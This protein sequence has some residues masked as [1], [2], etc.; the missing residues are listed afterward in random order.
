MRNLTLAAI[1]AVFL[2][3]QSGC[4]GSSDQETPCAGGVVNTAAA[5]STDIV[6][7]AR[8]DQYVHGPW[9][10]SVRPGDIK[11]NARIRIYDAP[12]ANLAVTIDHRYKTKNSKQ[13][14]VLNVVHPS[15]EV[16]DPIRIKALDPVQ[17]Q[18]RATLNTGS[19]ELPADELV[20]MQSRTLMATRDFTVIPTRTRASFIVRPQLDSIGGIDTGWLY[21]IAHEKESVLECVRQNIAD[22]ERRLGETIGD[23]LADYVDD[24]CRACQSV[25]GAL[26]NLTT[27]QE[28]LGNLG[29]DL[30]EAALAASGIEG[31]TGTTI[32]NA[33]CT[34]ASYLGSW[35]T[36]F[37]TSIV[38]VPNPVRYVC[39]HTELLNQ[40]LAK[41]K[42]NADCMCELYVKS[43]TCE[44]R[45]PLEECKGIW[46]DMIAG[47]P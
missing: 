27:C 2:S 43:P 12:D 46:A 7:D 31:W 14:V 5:K 23:Q 11:E 25:A 16:I 1:A 24:P 42:V 19:T 3:Y 26:T 47:K 34:G 15:S 36:S 35:A 4:I 9:T 8:G 39:S 32:T 17:G 41:Y 22:L 44:K 45:Q 10:L 13:T 18:I 6:L 33:M 28:L 20:V 40:F 29:A 37:V 38:D 30:C 21:T